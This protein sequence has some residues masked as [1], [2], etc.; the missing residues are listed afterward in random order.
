MNQQKQIESNIVDNIYN[1]I[2]TAT[3]IP[4]PIS[5]NELVSS[6]SLSERENIPF[7]RSPRFYLGIVLNSR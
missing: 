4:Y 2:S 5:H 1:R 3:E 6:L 7:S